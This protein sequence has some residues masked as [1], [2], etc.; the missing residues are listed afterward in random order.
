MVGTQY[1]R[2]YCMCIPSVNF[3]DDHSEDFAQIFR[4]QTES[5]REI[6]AAPFVLLQPQIAQNPMQA[7]V[8]SAIPRFLAGLLHGSCA[9][10]NRETGTR[11]SDMHL[12]YSYYRN[13]LQNYK[14]KSMLWGMAVLWL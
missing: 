12:K 3:I 4:L 9:G 8:F 14:D 10:D 5:R 13:V 7:A 1:S 6:L 11:N 2:K